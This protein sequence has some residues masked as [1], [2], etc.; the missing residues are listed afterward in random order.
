MSAPT[1]GMSGRFQGLNGRLTQLAVGPHLS[2]R[3]VRTRLALIYGGL[4]LLSGAAL[5]AIAYALLVNAG[6]VFTIPAGPG[7][8]QATPLIRSAAGLPKHTAGRLPRQAGALPAHPSAATMA[9]WRR[10]AQCMREHGVRGFPDP[11]ASTPSGSLR[12]SEIAN[13]DGA[14][15]VIPTTIDQQSPVFTRASARCQL[16]PDVQRAAAQDNR[17]RTQ[18]REQLLLR[19][20]IALGGMSLLSLALGWLMA[21]RVLQPLE[22]AHEAQRQFVANA[23]HELRG[24]LTRQR[25]LIQVALSDPQANAASLRAAH[26]RALAAEQHLEQMIDAL[27]ALTRG[28][29]GLQHQERVDL[30][31]AASQALLA[32]ESELGQSG[33]EVRRAL[34]PARFQGDPRLIERLVVNLVQNA[35]RHNVPGGWLEVTTGTRQRL[36]FVSVA[37]TGPVIDPDA[38]ERLFQPFE[39]LGTAR[40]SHGGGHGLGLSIVRAVARAHR[41]TVSA[42]PRPEG[43]LVVEIA[44]PLGP[45]SHS[46]MA[47]LSRRVRH[48]NAGATLGE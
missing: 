34:A 26:E 33:L 43:G 15:F 19:S 38:I 8:N 6:F 24:P 13:R 30:E 2:Y 44:F 18:V 46:R 10:V 27:L 3:A 4:F 11:R 9:H 12:F 21:G 28:Q 20:G 37:N 23:S 42:Q 32:H 45:E 48:A 41:A 25:A 17:R 40:T 35:V 29:A 22:A 1:P 39:R 36:A 16:S 7:A 31:S 14:V 5:M 47:V